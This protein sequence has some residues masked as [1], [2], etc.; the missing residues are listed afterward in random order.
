MLAYITRHIGIYA[1]ATNQGSNLG[2]HFN[3][4]FSSLVSDAGGNA[5]M[6]G[7]V[8]QVERGPTPNGQGKPRF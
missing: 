2:H 6:D 5:G 3:Q 4:I 7:I 1:I 8:L